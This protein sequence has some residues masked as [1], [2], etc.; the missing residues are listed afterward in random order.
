[1]EPRTQELDSQAW[2][3]LVGTWAIDATHPMLPD[4]E[5][6]G[7]MTFEWL[8]GHRV[9]I[10]RSDYDHPEIPDAVAIFGVIDEE[11]SMHYFDSRGVHRIF[12]VSLS[13]GILR[14]A[15]NAPG[16][17]QRITLT[18]RDDGNTIAGQAELSRDG[19]NWQDDLTITYRRV[20]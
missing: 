19:T 20:R 12:T 13:E 5:I 17:S 4:D 11:L 1:M 10:Q 2:Q 8:D 18:I 15:R 7:Q 16:F 9:L 3:T 6:R 14:C